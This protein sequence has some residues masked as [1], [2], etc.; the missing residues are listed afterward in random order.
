LMER[1]TSVLFHFARE[2]FSQSLQQF[3]ALRRKAQIDTRL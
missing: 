3:F 1:K 2:R